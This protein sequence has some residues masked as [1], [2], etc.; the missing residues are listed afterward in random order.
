[1]V[2]AFNRLNRTINLN[3]MQRE[4][5]PLLTAPIPVSSKTTPDL[6]EGPQAEFFRTSLKGIKG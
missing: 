4:D 6:K 5:T 3:R 1:M 2:Q